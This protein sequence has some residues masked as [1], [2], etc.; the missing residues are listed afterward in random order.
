MPQPGK[1]S[2]GG[3]GRH[4]LDIEAVGKCECALV[5]G[6]PQTERRLDDRFRVARLVGTKNSRRTR[7]CRSERTSAAG[8]WRED[9][10]TVVPETLRLTADWLG[11]EVHAVA[12]QSIPDRGHDRRGVALKRGK[13]ARSPATHRRPRPRRSFHCDI[14]RA[15]MASTGVAAVHGASNRLEPG[16]PPHASDT[17]AS[18]VW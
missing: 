14:A 13:R 12:V 10:G 4:D 8:A 9:D 3:L 6:T 5:Y 2:A 11:A 17:A 18:G 7:V 1:R 16:E 15:T